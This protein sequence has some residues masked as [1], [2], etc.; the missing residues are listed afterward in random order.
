MVVMMIDDGSTLTMLCCVIGQVTLRALVAH[1]N[2]S[3]WLVAQAW[4]CQKRMCAA[5]TTLLFRYTGGALVYCVPS[6][7]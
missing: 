2:K 3:L 4:E 6:L 5:L 7:H 1:A